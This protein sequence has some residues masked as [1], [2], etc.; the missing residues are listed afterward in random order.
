[1][2][3]TTGMGDRLGFAAPQD[4]VR[5]LQCE[6]DLEVIDAFIVGD[7]RLLP[8]H[9]EKLMKILD[10]AR[11]SRAAG[12]PVSLGLVG[13]TDDSGK[14]RMNSGLSLS[15]AHEVQTFFIR[16]GVQVHDASGEG[17]LKPR[18]PND[19]PTHRAM[20]RRVEI[21]VCVAAK[22]PGARVRTA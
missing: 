22:P 15:R 12:F 10:K 2:Y 4:D 21:M 14:E 17:E 18:V 16:Q 20:N 5:V 8:R 7:Y 9:Y 13:H 1:M 6:P 3:V 19:S 11:S